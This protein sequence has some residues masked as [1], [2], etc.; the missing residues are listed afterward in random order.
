MKRSISAA[1]LSSG[2]SPDK[3]SGRICLAGQSYDHHPQRTSGQPE[4]GAGRRLG[5]RRGC[6]DSGGFP[7]HAS[8]LPPQ[9]LRRTPQCTEAVLPKLRAPDVVLGKTKRDGEVRKAEVR[10]ETHKIEA[11]VGFLAA[12][13]MGK[14]KPRHRKNDTAH[15]NDSE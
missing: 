2:R 8:R 1:T 5:D 11:F 9:R 4:A 15:R 14:K 13:F 3:N 10:E 6:T 12:G 7:R